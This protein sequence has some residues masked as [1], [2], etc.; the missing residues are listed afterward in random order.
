M[1]K[2]ALA[3]TITVRKTFQGVGVERV[4]PIHSPLVSIEPVPTAGVP[5][6]RRAKLYFLR[7]R[8]GKAAKLKQ[9]FVSKDKGTPSSGGGASAGAA[10]GSQPAAGAAAAGGA[11]AARP[12]KAAAAAAAAAAAPE[13]ALV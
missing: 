13:P 3:S 10:G 12:A 9:Y 11:A 5:R 1:H 4:F 6:V 7:D 8:V 2:H